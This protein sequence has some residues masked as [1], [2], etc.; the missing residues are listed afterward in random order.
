MN[1]SDPQSNRAP[2]RSSKPSLIEKLFEGLL[3]NSRFSVLL[4]VIFG[5]IG[6]LALFILGSIEIIHT[7]KYFLPSEQQTH[8]YAPVLIGIIGAIDL[9]LI[10]IVLL[11]FSFGIYELFISRL[12]IARDSGGQHV[13]DISS[14]DELKNKL[15][16]V[17]IMVLIVTFFKAILS[18]S[19]SSPIEMLYLAIAILA[20]TAGAFLLRKSDRF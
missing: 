15:L 7:L 12:D 11:I 5:V 20:I 13:L 16:K 1:A 2:N 3:W 9:Y 8:N 19:F 4:A 14:L 17:I 18:T 6:A 10:A